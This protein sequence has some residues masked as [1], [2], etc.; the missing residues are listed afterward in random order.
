[1]QEFAEKASYYM[2]ELNMI[3]PF[4]EGNGRAIREFIRC[5][6]LKAGYDMDWSFIDSNALLD[7]T[8]VAVN[9]DFKPLTDCLLAAVTMD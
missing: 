8:T 9:G 6:A 3:H 5:L 2:S 4:R 1:M 7:A